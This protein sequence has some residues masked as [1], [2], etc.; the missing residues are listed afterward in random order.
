MVLKTPRTGCLCHA[1]T[2]ELFRECFPPGVVNVVH[3]AGRE[4][5]PPLMK[6][7]L[8][9]VFA[10]IGTSK[11]AVELQRLHPHPNRLR[12]C[13]A[14]DAKNPAIVCADA[15]LDVAVSE[16]VL[17]SLSFNG[18]RCTALKIIHVHES[19]ADR[20]VERMAAAVDALKIGLPWAPGVSITP[21]PEPG[22]PAYIAELIADAVVK[23]ARV[24]NER[25]GRADKSIV[26][27][28]LLYPV[29]PAMRVYQEEQFGPVVPIAPF[30]DMDQICDAV[31]KSSF[32]QQ[33]SIFSTS[34][35]VVSTLLDRFV[36]QVSR[37]NVNA[38]CQRGPDILP[39][40]GRY[41]WALRDHAPAYT[42][43]RSCSKNSAYGTLS[44][45]DAL[46]IFSIRSVMATKDTAA[47]KQLFSEVMNAHQSKYLHSSFMF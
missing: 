10:F 24:V 26:A 13:L 41:A 21:L 15:D 1:P 39:F 33:A 11:A 20:F 29:T 44:V 30:S 7:G 18:Q 17:G 25:G 3:G 6:S 28:T 46:R 8:V 43:V 14:L 31:S 42:T 5:L 40:T 2:L 35:S 4:T 34:A 19:I 23:G 37:V 32:G 12:V 9:D 22:K 16:C 45:K 36:S 27:P 38:Q 47:N